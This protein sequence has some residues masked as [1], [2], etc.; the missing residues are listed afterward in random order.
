MSFPSIPNGS[1]IKEQL[2]T[3][4]SRSPNKRPRYGTL[5]DNIT[6]LGQERMA[7]L[8]NQPTRIDLPKAT[9]SSP[10]Q[11]TDIQDVTEE[12]L[13]PFSDNQFER[14]LNAAE[15]FFRLANE[16]LDSQ[17]E[18]A[19]IRCLL[20][21]RNYY[22]QLTDT[23][24][25]IIACNSYISEIYLSIAHNFLNG[26]NYQEA[27]IKYTKSLEFKTLEYQQ[28]IAYLHPEDYPDGNLREYIG[29]IY[30]QLGVCHLELES[31][32]EAFHHFNKALGHLEEALTLLLNTPEGNLHNIDVARVAI[33]NTHLRIGDWLLKQ[34]NFKQTLEQY[35]KAL[36]IENERDPADP[37][38][39][40]ACL[41]SITDAH[42]ELAN[43]CEKNHDISGLIHHT[44]RLHSLIRNLCDET[45]ET[46]EN[47]INIANIYQKLGIAYG[48]KDDF[49]ESVKHLEKALVLRHKL[50]EM[51]N[52]SEES[53]ASLNKSKVLLAE[54]LCNN[55]YVLL[56]NGDF[57]QALVR[58]K[59]ALEVLTDKQPYDP[60]Q[61]NKC[62]QFLKHTYFK[63]ANRCFENND[64]FRGITYLKEEL[65]IAT[66]LS[67]LLGQNRE[68]S[69]WVADIHEA[70][71]YA[72]SRT[73]DFPHA[74]EYFEQVLVLRKNIFGLEE[75]IIKDT[76]LKVAEFHAAQAKSLIA[77]Y[78]SS[79]QSA[80][81]ESDQRLQR[82][83]N[84]RHILHKE[85][86][87]LIAK[88]N[89]ER[90]RNFNRLIS[91]HN[92]AAFQSTKLKVG[93][94]RIRALEML[95]LVKPIEDPQVQEML[96][97]VAQNLA[98]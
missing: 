66:F 49:L 13:S 78:E 44:E 51:S 9:T 32:E 97:L 83:K 22:Q 64:Y 76:M 50:F 73:K 92:R 72:F 10:L 61:I 86:R 43:I 23:D 2:A 24:N 48:R 14:T 71:G 47:L 35:E 95:A 89:E 96:R 39:L 42:V 80:I 8:G 58:S 34:R 6:A 88:Q 57:D 20:E 67:N 59:N 18:E 41:L 7:N 65:S 82:I 91:E 93:Q 11:N 75:Q 37:R 15:H 31:F 55:T 77:I 87:P 84:N 33:S 54:V 1:P 98:A 29:L 81:R 85:R 70:L 79:R 69:I 16:N 21:C 56:E 45:G 60:N 30:H 52:G 62:S 25:Q 19:A 63:L 68:I 46:K 3:S 94:H 90:V 5:A 17:N 74:I 26:E 4:P 53:A 12:N 36:K 27:I 38:R 28:S 40:S